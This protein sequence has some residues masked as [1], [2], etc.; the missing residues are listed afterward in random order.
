MFNCPT[1]PLGSSW[2]YT[3]IMGKPTQL[4][5]QWVVF[6]K[7]ATMEQYGILCGLMLYADHRYPF[8]MGWFTRSFHPFNNRDSPG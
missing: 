1:F 2:D 7:G 4:K 8:P 3:V 5:I 6:F